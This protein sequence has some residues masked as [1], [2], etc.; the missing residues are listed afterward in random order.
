VAKDAVIEFPQLGAAGVILCNFWHYQG[1]CSCF[2]VLMSATQLLQKSP[3]DLGKPQRSAGFAGP[4]H[5]SHN[6]TLHELL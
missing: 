5:N 4:A 2:L 6:Y 3:K 1:L